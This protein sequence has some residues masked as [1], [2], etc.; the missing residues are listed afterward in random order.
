MK[1]LIKGAIFPALNHSTGT[2]TW[3]SNTKTVTTPEDD[4]QERQQVL[5][6]A[7]WY[8]DEYSAHM[9]NK[10]GKR[11]MNMH[12]HRC[13]MILKVNTPSKLFMS[14][15]GKGMLAF[16]AQLLLIYKTESKED[17]AD[18]EYYKE[19]SDLSNIS[20]YQ[21]INRLQKLGDI[22]DSDKGLHPKVYTPRT[23]T[24]KL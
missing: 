24:T 13:C 20:R 9:S 5:K 3:D 21:L 15:L 12:H 8:K 16:W 1:A 2:C 23:N 7:A 14:I 11:K 19:S 18:D 6:D 4:E 17:V 22:S 10:A